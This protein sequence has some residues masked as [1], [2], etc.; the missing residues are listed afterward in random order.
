MFR[1]SDIAQAF[2]PDERIVLYPNDC[3][4]LL[5]QIPDG[6]MQERDGEKETESCPIP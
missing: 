6:T 2:A 1:K 5:R 3:L 4:E